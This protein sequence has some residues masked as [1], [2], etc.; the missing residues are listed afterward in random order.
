MS[1]EATSRQLCVLHDWKREIEPA[2][3]I[4]RKEAVSPG[5]SQSIYSS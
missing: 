1:D 4:T 2:L 3:L 5:E